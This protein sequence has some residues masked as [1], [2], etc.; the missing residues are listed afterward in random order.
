MKLATLIF[1]IVCLGSLAFA[2]QG[3]CIVVSAIPI[4]DGN[5]SCSASDTL[6]VSGIVQPTCNIQVTALASATQLNITAGENNTKIA[7]VKESTNNANGYKVSLSSLNNGR[8][9]NGALNFA[10][11]IS[12]NGGGLISPASAATVVKT[13]SGPLASAVVEDSD[14]K[15]TFPAQASALAGTYSDTLTFTL[16]TL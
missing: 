16:T 2:G 4:I 5:G 9:V 10:Y 7:S 3:K 14:V 8:L 15:I 1:S 13:K 11:Q 12:Y 6:V